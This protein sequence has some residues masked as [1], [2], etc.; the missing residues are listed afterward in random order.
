M[1]TSNYSAPITPGVR[2]KMYVIKRAGHEDQGNKKKKE[3]ANGALLN[4][5]YD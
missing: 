5:V 3:T 2:G 4:E 1:R